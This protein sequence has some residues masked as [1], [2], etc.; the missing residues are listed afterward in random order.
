MMLNLFS[1]FDPSTKFLSL[2]WMS[3]FIGLMFIPQ[4]Y[5]VFNSR[6]IYLLITFMNILWGE[7]KVILKI[8]FNLNNLMFYMGMFIFI[9]MNNFMGLFPYIF[10][11]SSHLV[12]SLSLS[13]PM[14]LGLMFFGWIKNTKFMLC[15]LVPQGTP[16]MLMFFMVLIESLSNVIR[17]FTLAIRLTAN[18]IAGHLLL[19]L[20]S[21]FIPELF[22][23]YLVVL[24]VQL[25]LLILEISVS[26]IQSYVFV[27][28][29]I[30]YLKET[31]YDEI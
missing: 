2:N 16:F 10:T 17:P 30:L 5:W 27:I 1:I 22:I 18:M 13:L 7:F 24:L 8:K 15:H 14:W 25:M 23:L 26:L 29:M 9:M 21:S 19:T 12:Y 6:I 4:M 31:N 28:L 11:S 20:L 3:T